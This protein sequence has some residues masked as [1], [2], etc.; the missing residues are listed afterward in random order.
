MAAKRRSATADGIILE[1]FAAFE[2]ED[3]ISSVWV[4]LWMRKDE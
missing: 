1:L 4:C 3:T 2:I